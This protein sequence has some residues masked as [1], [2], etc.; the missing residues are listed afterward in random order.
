MITS[1]YKT[2][3]LDC[4]WP[5]LTGKCCAWKKMCQ[6]METISS[7]D[8]PFR[9]KIIINNT[10][11]YESGACAL[12]NLLW[13]I[14]LLAMLVWTYSEHTH[15]HTLC[16]CA[17]YHFIKCKFKS[18][19]LHLRAISHSLG[20][21]AFASQTH[22]HTHT[23]QFLCTAIFSSSIISSF[24]VSAVRLFLSLFFF[25]CTVLCWLWKQLLWCA[26]LGSGMWLG[27]KKS[28]LFGYRK[29]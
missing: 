13:A 11:T 20:G 25:F 1:C 4:H 12:L 15:T 8:F 29:K 21:I 7:A 19:L 27:E 24:A 2:I 6:T 26:S 23:Q 22:T 17:K 10:T 14:C 28:N 3:T 5:T 18:L 9:W 16:T